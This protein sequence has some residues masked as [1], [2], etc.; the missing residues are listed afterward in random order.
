MTRQQLIFIMYL[1]SKQLTQQCCLSVTDFSLHFSL[2]KWK[3]HTCHRWYNI[4][5]YHDIP[6]GPRRPTGSAGVPSSAPDSAQMLLPDQPLNLRHIGRRRQRETQKSG[7]LRQQTGM[8]HRLHRIGL[9]PD[10]F[11]AHQANDFLHLLREEGG[12]GVVD[13][14][15]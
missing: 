4:H 15:G 10:T 7:G 9:Q 5:Q 1:L 3:C 11:T 8:S 2:Y 13:S 6:S 12:D 14:C